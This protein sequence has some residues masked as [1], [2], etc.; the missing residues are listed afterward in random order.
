MVAISLLLEPFCITCL[1]K[2][3][4]FEVFPDAVTV[5]DTRAL[6]WPEMPT[7]FFWEDK[8]LV[9]TPLKE[10]AWLL[11]QF[12]K[13]LTLKLEVCWSSKK[14]ETPINWTRDIKWMNPS[15]GKSWVCTTA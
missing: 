1:Q 7:V 9:Q 2:D 11:Q 15:R 3:M 6:F 4:F 10:G 12:G 8:H 13:S 5:H 14:K